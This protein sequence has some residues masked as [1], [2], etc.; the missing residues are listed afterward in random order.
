MKKTYPYAEALAVAAQIVGELQASCDR[1]HIAGSLRREKP[2]VG[3]IEILYVPKQISAEDDMFA[4]SK[5]S[6]VDAILEK[7]LG[8]GRLTKRLNAFHHAT[9]G[10]E[11][12]YAVHC[13][14]GIPV[15]FFATTEACWFNYLVCRTGPL[16]LN[17]QIA[18]LA[19]TR[20]AKWLSTGEGFL[21]FGEQR[22][23]PMRSE[24]EVFAFVGLEYR[25]PKQRC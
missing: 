15:D 13:A 23:I 14:S 20:G 22:R 6:A 2:Q 21:S 16:S 24:Q 8:A 1:I 25:E 5:V 19:H 4:P 11:N 18:S 3:D 17:K 7:M 10:P 12:K 9:W